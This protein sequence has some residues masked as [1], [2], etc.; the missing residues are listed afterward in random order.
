MKNEKYFIGDLENC[1]YLSSL[2]PKGF[3]TNTLNICNDKRK[4]LQRYFNDY[5]KN[6][7]N[8]F[9]SHKIYHSIHPLYIVTHTMNVQ[10]Y[11]TSDL[12]ELKEGTRFI[13]SEKGSYPIETGLFLIETEDETLYVA[14]LSEVKYFTVS[15][16]Y[17]GDNK[18]KIYVPFQL[19]SHKLNFWNEHL[20]VLFH[21]FDIRLEYQ[22]K[23][24]PFLG[25]LK[26]FILLQEEELY[27]YFLANILNIL[28]EAKD[29]INSDLSIKDKEELLRETED[30]L[31]KLKNSINDI[32]EFQYDTIESVEYYIQKYYEKEEIKQNEQEKQEYEARQKRLKEE[33]EKE[34][35]RIKRKKEYLETIKAKSELLDYFNLEITKIS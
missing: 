28:T 30:V 26:D 6:N 5:H 29:M 9:D 15:A 24:I 2:T 33:Q 19:L 18:D 27:P 11:E 3:N 23:F 12:Y 21:T 22:I 4:N 17:F 10:K 7:E 31:Y 34:Q 32:A 35:K 13:E 14:S 20:N 1:Y 16:I 8:M 25:V